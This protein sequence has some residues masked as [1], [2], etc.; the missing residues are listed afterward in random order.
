MV[1]RRNV[2]SLHYLPIAPFL[3]LMCHQNQFAPYQTNLSL[4]VMIYKYSS[5]QRRMASQFIIVW[6]YT[7]RDLSWRREINEHHSLNWAE[8][9]V[10]G[11]G[12]STC[13]RVSAHLVDI[14]EKLNSFLR[15]PEVLILKLF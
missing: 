1:T 9:A 3:V 6:I 8:L 14:I 11:L 15:W 5:E 10:K 7:C 12:Y 2:C 13:Y 4:N